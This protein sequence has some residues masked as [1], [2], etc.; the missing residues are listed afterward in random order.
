M[1]DL[2]TLAFDLAD[3]YRTPVMILSDAQVGQM[4][5]P[6]VWKEYTPL[7]GLP[8]KDWALTGAKGRKKRTI[9][10]F[11]LHPGLLEKHN[12]VL[13]QTY[14]RIRENEVRCEEIRTQDADLV[15]VAYGTSAR[16]AKGLVARGVEGGKVGLL[17][18]I[19]LWPF[20]EKR[21]R[22]LADAGKDF[23][24]VEMSA[25]QM[26]EDVR[27]AV[28]GRSRVG[29]YGEVGATVVTVE[30][31]AEKAREMLISRKRAR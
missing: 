31:T 25:G 24:V 6:L 27:L 1:A 4:M 11:F 5:E 10:S 8:P 28:E 21:I 26:V 2:A 3:M 15:L 18:P 20:P 13:Q 22:E 12:I 17:R 14:A 23:L 9:R 29:L 16:I 30:K 7:V 19:T